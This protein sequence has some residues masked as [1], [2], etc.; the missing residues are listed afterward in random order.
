MNLSLPSR[1]DIPFYI[2]GG[3]Y[4]GGSINY[5][6]PAKRGYV[7]VYWQGRYGDIT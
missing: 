3:D 2:K 7:Q 6:K 1:N 5:H 4:M